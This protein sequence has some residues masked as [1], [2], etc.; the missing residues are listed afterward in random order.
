M[1]VDML[2]VANLK[3]HTRISKKTGKE[4]KQKLILGGASMGAVA[5]TP[6]RGCLSDG[7]VL[8]LPTICRQRKKRA[9]LEEEGVRTAAAAE[10]EETEATPT[11]SRK[12]CT[13]QERRWSLV[14]KT[15]RTWRF[16]LARAT[17]TTRRKRLQAMAKMRFAL[18][19]DC[20][21]A[22]HPLKSAEELKKLIPT[23]KCT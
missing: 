8:V 6:P 19:W 18:S 20:G 4:K 16:L 2:K 5:C 23:A 13:C 11:A 7:I 17:F 21:D 12:R 1:A 15:N 9:E 10:V 3:Q 14:C 22:T